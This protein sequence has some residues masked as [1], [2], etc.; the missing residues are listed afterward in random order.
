MDDQ[1]I[2]NIHKLQHADVPLKFEV[3]S[4]LM[5]LIERNIYQAGSKLPSEQDLATAFGVSRTTIRDALALLELQGILQR[6]HGTGTYVREIFRLLDNPMEMNLGVSEVLRRNDM[7]PGVQKLKIRLAKP[8]QIVEKKLKTT[9]DIYIIERTR[10]GDSIPMVFT[11]DHMPASIVPKGIDVE[12]ISRGSLYEFLESTCGIELDYGLSTL[13]PELA[14]PV[15]AERLQIPVG[16]P[17]ILMEQLDFSTEGKPILLSC[18]YYM[19]RGIRFSVLRR[20]KNYFNRP[21]ELINDSS[22]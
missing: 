21:E 6:K 15:L 3:S 20:R 11:I 22:C 10:T 4:Q 2:K 12:E 9:G 8:S 14:D 17:V 16:C 19:R 18:E 7:E 13:I 1:K 5:D